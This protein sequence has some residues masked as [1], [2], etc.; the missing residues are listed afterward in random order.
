MD[1]NL[2]KIIGNEI[3]PELAKELNITSIEEYNEIFSKENKDKNKNK[4][5]KNKQNK[6]SNSKLKEMRKKEMVLNKKIK[7]EVR[8]NVLESLEKHF[9]NFKDKLQA[10]DLEC[11]KNL[12]K[13]R[14]ISKEKL[15][16]E[17]DKS[18]KNTET[19]IES[20]LRNDYES[21]DDSSSMEVDDKQINLGQTKETGDNEIKTPDST[22]STLAS[23]LQ[24]DPELKKQILDEIRKFREKEIDLEEEANEINSQFI[25][26]E[27]PDKSNL[28]IVDRQE[29]IQNVRINLPIVKYEHEIMDKINNSLVT[30]ICGETGSGKSTQIPQF[31]YEYGY[32]KALGQIV[33]TQPRRV[34]A[35]SLAQRVSDELNVKL[36]AEVGYQVRYD[37]K[38]VSDKTVLRYITDGILLKELESDNLL[39][40]YSVVIIDE[41]HERTINTDI[42]IGLLSKTIRWRYLLA[43]HKV[44]LNKEDKE[45]KPLRLVIMS[46]TMRVDE[47]MESPVFRP[48]II[49]SFVKVEARQFPVTIHHAKR[50][51]HDYVEESFKLCCKIHSKLPAGGILIFLTGKNEI[52][53][54]CSKLRKEF[55]NIKIKSSISDINLDKDIEEDFVV[56]GADDKINIELS[57]THDDAAAKIEDSTHKNENSVETNQLVEKIFSYKS[58]NI[59]PLYSSLTNE[60]QMKVFANQDE[61]KRLIVIATNVAETSI[62]IPNIRYVI[63]CGRSKKRI[64][65]QGLSFSTF[66]IE[67]ISQASS[68]QRSGRAGRTGPGYCY[69]LYSNG[70]YSKMERYTEPQILSC[71]LDQTILYLKSLKIT[72]V[73][74]FPF[75][76]FPEKIFV[77]R[78]L[79]HLIIIGGLQAEENNLVKLKIVENEMNKL[80]KAESS[81]IDYHDNTSI[82]EIGKLM[83]KFP[84][85][86]KYSKIIILANKFGLLHY[87][88]VLVGVLN[89]ENIF[90]FQNEDKDQVN[91]TPSEENQ[92]QTQK[93][94]DPFKNK[95][96]LRNFLDTKLLN[97]FSDALTYLNLILH[98][99]KLQDNSQS[100]IN[101]NN[102]ERFLNFF[103][104]KYFLNIKRMKEIFDLIEQLYKICRVTFDEKLT[105]DKLYKIEFPDSDTQN[106]LIQILVTAFIDN[107]ARRRVIYDKIGNVE[108]RTKKKVIY[109]CNENNE[110]C[111]IHPQSL[112]SK[113]NAD[114]VIYKE[115][116]L[117]NKTFI[118]CNTII[119][120]EYIFNIGG[121]LVSSNLIN[122]S[123]LN[124]PFYNKK[125]D[126][127][128]CFVNIKYGYK[129]W[130][131][132]NVR[133]EMKREDDN[134]VR[135]FARFILEGKV[136]EEFKQFERYLNSK[137]SI[138]T[139]QICIM[140]KV[141]MLINLFKINKIKSRKDLINKCGKDKR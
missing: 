103:C 2:E 129:S 125:D 121:D 100:K 43:K 106:L 114:F 128:N 39:L 83:V 45:V 72:D 13:K 35:V 47:F 86:P 37:S 16:E 117:D 101:S 10:D 78:A 96:D 133:V 24:L 38:F 119:K 28:I 34:A 36:G 76:T 15:K 65:T 60:E 135:F 61:N 41:A 27:I 132:S 49:P 23:P 48:K 33:I 69:R 53:Y 7:N 141:T 131:I 104:D 6:I 138:I 139:N 71:P 95:K 134:F 82:T 63:D 90:N 85:P 19:F 42:I 50:T 89:I 140:P 124:E 127:I 58:A 105:S 21:E 91:K 54:L 118:V 29:S 111:Q 1:N 56:E 66:K 137:P 5:N 108:D 84:L 126:E 64:F 11:A 122:S 9:I 112:L 79:R 59:L 98:Y 14:K 57:K 12:G 25:N 130:E 30:V 20:E 52:N 51:L 32:T 120:P 93:Q 115:I 81:N 73:S 92:K 31:L 102:K 22:P 99:F 62:T 110:E 88:I 18:I 17:E 109:E 70:L 80:N 40:K 116:I 3:S 8:S 97:P 55:E 44:R 46:A 87:A 136:F 77:E 123:S 113:S 75:L 94:N 26:L 67:W 74:K 68:E 107:I 4:G